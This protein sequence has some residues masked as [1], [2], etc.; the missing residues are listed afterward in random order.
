MVD[1]HNEDMLLSLNTALSSMREA[2]DT[3]VKI[4]QNS[5]MSSSDRITNVN[6]IKVAIANVLTTLQNCNSDRYEGTSAPDLQLSTLR[7]D[8]IGG[9][10]AVGTENSNVVAKADFVDHHGESKSTN[11][12]VEV[13]WSSSDGGIVS[14]NSSTGSYLALVPGNVTVTARH[15][16]GAVASVPLV[17][18]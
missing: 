7:V 2:L 14:I 9:T 13:V 16:G 17:V 1:I 12:I 10:V 4:E 3:T 5:S 6:I 8:N 18:V 15:R 11:Q